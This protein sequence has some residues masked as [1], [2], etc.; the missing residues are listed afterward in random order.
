MHKSGFVE[1]EMKGYM[2]EAGL[3]DFALVELGEPVVMEIHGKDIT[4]RLF[5]ARGRKA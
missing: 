3:V 5:F 1:E 4:R 2:A